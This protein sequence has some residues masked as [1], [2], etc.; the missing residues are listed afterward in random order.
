MLFLSFVSS[1]SWFQN[2]LFICHYDIFRG[3]SSDSLFV[4]WFFVF[5]KITDFSF[6]SNFVIFMNGWYSSFL[7]LFNIMTYRNIVRFYSDCFSSSFLTRISATIFFFFF[8]YSS[9]NRISWT[10]N[11]HL[12]CL[13][14]VIRALRKYMKFLW[15]VITLLSVVFLSRYFLH[16][17][18][19]W[20]IIIHSFS[21]II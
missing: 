2:N 8:L 3:S 10:F 13:R 1:F 12:A 7:T 14:L 4:Q 5:S 21:E 16:F 20:I 9:L 15:S 19:T 18:I 11:V 6:F 17:L